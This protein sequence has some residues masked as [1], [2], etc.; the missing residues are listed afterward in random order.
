VRNTN[1]I[2]WFR[3]MV[4]AIPCG[5]ILLGSIWFFA[6]RHIPSHRARLYEDPISSIRSIRIVPGDSFSLVDREVLIADVGTIQE[7]MAALRSAKR[8]SLNHPATKWSCSLTISSATGASYVEV[9]DTLGQGTILR[10]CTSPH[11]LFFDTLQ[12]DTIGHL[13][14]HAAQTKP[15]PNSR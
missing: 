1:S 8:Y 4:V 10:C 9:I 15:Q 3:V 5:V 7:I 13:L 2:S 11:G 6:A 14:E 12:S